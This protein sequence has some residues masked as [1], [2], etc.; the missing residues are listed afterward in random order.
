MLYMYTFKS[1]RDF[2]FGNWSSFYLEI[3]LDIGPKYSPILVRLSVVCL[4]VWFCLP[5]CLPVWLPVCLV[6]R[7]TLKFPVYMQSQLASRAN[8]LCRDMQ[9]CIRRHRQT[10]GQGHRRIQRRVIKRHVN[11]IQFQVI[12]YKIPLLYVVSIIYSRSLRI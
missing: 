11:C 7:T 6:G 4:P 12:K 9:R 2:I 5:A 10:Q 1:E 3:L 8:H